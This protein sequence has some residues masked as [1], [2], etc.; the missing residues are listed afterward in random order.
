MDWKEEL[1]DLLEKQGLQPRIT[2][3]ISSKQILDEQTALIEKII[4]DS[5]SQLLDKVSEGV[6]K[7]RKV[8]DKD[9]EA[10]NWKCNATCHHVTGICLGINTAVDKVKALIQEEKERLCN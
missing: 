4:E 10:H 8:D 2:E 1:K 9:H 6:E 5:N 7:L 3:E